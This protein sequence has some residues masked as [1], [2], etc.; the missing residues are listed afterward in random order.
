MLRTDNMADIL[1]PRFQQIFDERFTNQ[2]DV[3]SKFY[4]FKPSRLIT[5]RFSTLGTMDVVPRFLGSVDYDDVYQGYD[6][7]VTPLEHAKGIQIQRRL[8]DTDQHDKID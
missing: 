4:S 1:D 7:A 6:V 2:P 8:F 5:E 3:V